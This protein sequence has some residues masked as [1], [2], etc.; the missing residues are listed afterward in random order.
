MSVEVHRL[1]AR[2]RYSENE[3]VSIPTDA[4]AARWRRLKAAVDNVRAAVGSSDPHRCP[5]A[6]A[7]A[8]DA[9]YDLWELW[10]RRSHLKFADQ[11][12]EVG[13]DPDGEL[14]AALIFA[15]GGKTHAQVEFGDFTDTISE[16]FFDHYGCW[17]WRPYHDPNPR[18]VKR[19]AWYASHVAYQEVLPVIERAVAWMQQRVAGSRST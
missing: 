11:D 19:D 9:L 7:N 2:C 4:L 1:F 10:V 12:C 18:L 3:W 15:R 17:R 13:G 6:V 16:S 5:D 8:L 14:V